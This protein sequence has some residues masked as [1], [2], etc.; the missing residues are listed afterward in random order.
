MKKMNALDCLLSEVG[1]LQLYIKPYFWK[2][3][4]IQPRSKSGP[5]MKD[6]AKTISALFVCDIY[7]WSNL[8]FGRILSRCMRSTQRQEDVG[9]VFTSLK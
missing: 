1:L 7:I 4:H 3:L 9:G 6:V 2:R 5:Q 8:F